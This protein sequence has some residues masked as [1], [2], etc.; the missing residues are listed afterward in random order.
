VP[1]P[2]ITGISGLALIKTFQSEYAVAAVTAHRY[3]PWHAG[4]CFVKCIQIP[5]VKFASVLPARCNSFIA[6]RWPL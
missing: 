1:G 3:S 6:A 5:T 2:L 4:H